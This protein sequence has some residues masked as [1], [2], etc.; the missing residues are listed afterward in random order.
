M[1]KSDFSEQFA[2][3]L[4]IENVGHVDECPEMEFQS[5]G[6]LVMK[7]T[8]REK[9]SGRTEKASGRRWRIGSPQGKGTHFN[10]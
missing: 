5:L 8:E 6:N 3:S 9:A 1:L 10:T 4:V 7:V 2:Y